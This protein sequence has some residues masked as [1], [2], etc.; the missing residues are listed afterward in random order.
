M[1]KALLVAFVLIASSLAPAPAFAWGSSAHRYIMR[2]AIDLLPPQLKPFF[3]AHRDEAVMRV[4]DPDLWR[5]IGWPEDPNHFVDFGVKEYGPY[6]FT[7]L[8][9]DYDAAVEK[10]GVETLR[11]YG[12]LPWRQEEEFGN[13]R[14][15]FEAFPRGGFAANNV[16]LF[17]AIAAHYIQDA[18]QPLHATDNY[19]GLAT[20]Q[21]GVHARFESA[22]F[23][24]YESKLT[25]TPPPL[26]PITNP[27]DAAFDTLLA[28]NRLVD[29]VL[30]A[31]KSA[32]AG[33]D[34]YD[35]EYFDKFLAGVKGVLEDQLGQAISAT[36]GLIVGA[37]EKAG[38]PALVSPPRQPQR[39]KKSGV[40]NNPPQAPAPPGRRE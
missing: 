31:D 40:R 15:A 35:D 23:E 4:I 25:I 6:P 30:A 5:A 27:R 21:D 3:D 1:R 33:K 36:A 34:V 38:R 2:R 26:R 18:T 22:L 17:S 9:R 32:A 28:S 16:V 8:P 13:L 39:V 20:G 29:R 24:R 10:F 14:R 7:A 11:R 37:W 19:D 12:T